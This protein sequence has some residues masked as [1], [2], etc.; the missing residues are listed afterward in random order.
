MAGS[1]SGLSL[2]R[3]IEDLRAEL[4]SAL[5]EGKGKPLQFNLKPIE[6]ELKVAVTATGSGKGSVKFWVVEV[7]AEGKVEH[8]STH[9]LKLSLEPIAPG[10]GPVQISSAGIDS[11]MQASKSEQ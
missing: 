11:P 4:M 7:G 9:T 6:L 2:A 3:V 5:E 10:G 1:E 8:A